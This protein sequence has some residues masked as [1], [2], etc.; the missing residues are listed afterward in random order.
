[1][2]TRTYSTKECR[3]C[4]K[5]I[6]VNGLAWSGHLK[7]HV[8]QGDLKT[9][10]SLYEPNLHLYVQQGKFYAITE[11]GEQKTKEVDR[12]RKERKAPKIFQAYASVDSAKDAVSGIRFVVVAANEDMA[13]NYIAQEAYHRFGCLNVEVEKPIVVSNGLVFQFDEGYE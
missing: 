1:M 5:E 3:F 12:I 10:T 11:Q 9:P 8:K 6:S 4:D 13:R 7:W 2:S